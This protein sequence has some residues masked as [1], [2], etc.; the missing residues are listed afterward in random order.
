MS[1]IRV[2]VLRGGPSSHYEDSLL[3]G[4]TIL[5]HLPEQYIPQDI[6]ISKE[7]TWHYGGL[8]ITPHKVFQN[9]DVVLNALHGTY[10]E[11][12]TLHETLDIF[13]PD[14]SGS[15]RLAHK[16]AGNRVLLKKVYRA[17]G[18]KTPYAALVSREGDFDQKVNELFRTFPLPAQFSSAKR[19]VPEAKLEHAKDFSSLR[20]SLEKLF[21]TEEQVIAEEHI[22]GRIALCG[23][24]E[25]FR[26]QKLYSFL[27]AELVGEK[28]TYPSVFSEA[29]KKEIGDLA[30]K[31]HE[32]LGARHYSLSFF[33]VHPK[34]GVY[35]LETRLLPPLSPESHFGE[36]LKHVGSSISEFLEHLI[37]LVKK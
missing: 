37:G 10:G 19:F 11:D 1:Q 28:L 35:I 23:V 5:K 20:S 8:P 36:F 34:R 4:G 21:E 6:F 7:G 17:H 14:Y 30:R 27:P 22:P 29:Q 2:A 15:D 31:A 32:V 26:G 18:L 13:E 25:G 33:V 24:L 3:T 12:G 16:V 9:T